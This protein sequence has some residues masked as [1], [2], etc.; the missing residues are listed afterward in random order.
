MGYYIEQNDTNFRINKDQFDAALAALKTLILTKPML[1]WVK[2]DEVLNAKTL[3][4]ALTACRWTPYMDGK[5]N[6]THIEFTCEK[7]GND[8]EIFGAIA[9]FVKSG[10]FIEMERS[11][12]Y[13]WKWVFKRKKLRELSGRIVYGEA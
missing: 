1:S 4:D 11:D 5:G 2:G 7:L 8:E 10:S 3:S 9:P 13:R 6:I 12:G